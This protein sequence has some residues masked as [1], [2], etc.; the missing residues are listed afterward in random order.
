MPAR[1][2]AEVLIQDAVMP[3][4]SHRQ[5]RLPAM[6]TTDGQTP[7]LTAFRRSLQDAARRGRVIEG[8]AELRCPR[9]HLVWSGPVNE[10]EA[11]RERACPVC[12]QSFPHRLL[13]EETFTIPDDVA[14]EVAA[15][16]RR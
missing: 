6:V 8:P 13:L 3:D 4:G 12:L 10:G 7:D 9:D 15:R 14:Q 5:I 2:W 11:N 1:D 16:R